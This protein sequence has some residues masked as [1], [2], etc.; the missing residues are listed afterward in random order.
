MLFYS[1]LFLL[2]ASVILPVGLLLWY[3]LKQEGGWKYAL[4]GMF[5]LVVCQIILRLPVLL[6]LGS[7]AALSAYMESHLLVYALVVSLLSAC[8]QCLLCWLFLRFALRQPLTAWNV[9]G[10]ALGYALME[11]L[12]F[13]GAGVLSALLGGDAPEGAQWISIVWKGCERIFMLVI[14]FGWIWLLGRAVRAKKPVLILA[15]FVL[16]AAVLFFGTASLNVWMLPEWLVELI[17]L[18]LALVLG[19]MIRKEWPGFDAAGQALKKE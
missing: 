18:V 11:S 12:L 15:A 8:F 16:L 17:L 6:V 13:S 19:W 2:A 4:W 5:A 3:C 9:L 10:F 7:N 1:E 14:D